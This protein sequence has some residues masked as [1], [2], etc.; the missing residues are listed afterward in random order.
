MII[1]HIIDVIGYS[2]SG[3]TS[4]IVNAIKSLKKNLNYNT[5]VIKNVK[6]HPVDKKG[7]DSYKFNEAGASFS[8]IQNINNHTA[9]FLENNDLNFESLLKWLQ[10]GPYNIDIIFTEGFRNFYNPTVLCVSNL[11]DIEEQLSENIK[12]ISGKICLGNLK[13]KMILNLPIIDIESEFF[14]FTGIFNLD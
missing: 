1:I 9:I 8:V 6:H 2:G 4:F 11:N 7:K 14:K 3:K 5:A 13:S 12:M 10:K